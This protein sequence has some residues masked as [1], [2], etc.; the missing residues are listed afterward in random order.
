[1]KKRIRRALRIGLFVLV[2][3]TALALLAYWV[4]FR[5]PYHENLRLR[6]ATVMTL[7]ADRHGLLIQNVNLVDVDRGIVVPE[8]TVRVLGETIDEVFIGKIP[9]AEPGLDVIDARGKY[10]MPGLFETHAHLGNGGIAPLEELESEVALE[11]FVLYG[12]TAIL[13]V[14]G[15][16]GN[17]EQ[18]AEFKRRERLGKI[19][20]PRIFGTGDMLTVPGSHPVGTL[21]GMSEDADPEIVHARGATVVE[22]GQDLAPVLQRKKEADLDGIK[23]VME[24]GPEP[25]Y[26]KPRM[27]VELAKQIVREANAVGLPVF[28]HISSA[29][30]L[31]DAVRAGAKAVVHG[32]HD[33][34]IDDAEI[35][36][37]R[38]RELYYIPTLSIYGMGGQ[39]ES[40]LHLDHVSKRA[41][42]SLN[43]PVFRFM[44]GRILKKYGGGGAYFETAKNNLARLHAAGVPIALGSDTNNP[45]IFPGCSAHLEMQLMAQAG[46]SNADILRIATLGSAELLGVEDEVGNVAP[47][48]LANLIILE[49]NPLEDIRN[50]WTIDK[51]VLKGRVIVPPVGVDP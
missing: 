39:F 32:V 9:K 13:S 10:L 45:F 6:A 20:A 43:N 8:V 27:S 37:M 18:I 31:A 19:V 14:G 16:G 3:V 38:S 44:M 46:L 17:N 33:T 22:E 51:V 4:W 7:P 21:W 35:E 15:T 12:V 23:I 30:E 5:N 49:E 42:R 40:D 34:L 48:H 28:V 24:S 11:Q 2:F 25:F 36:L 29:D 26:P 47:G 50:T 41:V 1:M